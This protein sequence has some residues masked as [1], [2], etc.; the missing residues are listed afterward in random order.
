MVLHAR[1]PANIPE[2]QDL[3]SVCA[4]LSPYEITVLARETVKDQ[5]SD[6][7]EDDHPWQPAFEVIHEGLLSMSS[8][9]QMLLT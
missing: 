2:Y 8:Q 4:S 6:G 3:H 7:K 9:R 1:A 5:G